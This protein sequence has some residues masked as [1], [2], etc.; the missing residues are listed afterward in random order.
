MLLRC[1]RV[2]REVVLLVLLHLHL[3]L[4]GHMLILGM[5]GILVI[6][7]FELVFD[8]V[9]HLVVFN[10]V[11]LNLV[12]NLVLDLMFNLRFDLRFR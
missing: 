3:R 5:L 12:F 1:R 9:L 7:V 2:W 11:V 6:L 10:L 8:L 4:V